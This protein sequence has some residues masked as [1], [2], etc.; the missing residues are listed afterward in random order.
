MVLRNKALYER[1]VVSETV[2]HIQNKGLDSGVNVMDIAQKLVRACLRKIRVWM[3]KY[4][5]VRERTFYGVLKFVSRI[6]ILYASLIL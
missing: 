4:V 3:D 1:K 6:C 5:D 2:Q